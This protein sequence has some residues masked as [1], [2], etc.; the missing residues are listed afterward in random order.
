[1]REVTYE[2]WQKNPTPRMMQVWNSTV[3]CK[4]KRMVLH[5]TERNQSH[6]VV[7][8]TSDN[9]TTANYKHCAEIEKPRRMTNRELARWLR[10]KPTRECKWTF[11]GCICSVHTYNEKV[12]NEEVHKDVVI[13]EDDGE[14]REPFVEESIMFEKEA[15][16]FL[17]KSLKVDDD[18]FDFFK[19]EASCKEEIKR[20][21]DF[22]EPR[23]KRIAELEKENAELKS[24]LRALKTSDY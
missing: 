18:E 8:L 23:E 19:N 4:V 24:E 20:L 6:P 12:E 2:D 3:G 17:K 10:E 9:I 22:I 11:D 13:R 1:M 15:E 16:D 14:W 21:T 7:V 5:F